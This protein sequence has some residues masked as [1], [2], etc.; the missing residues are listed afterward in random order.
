[1]ATDNTIARLRSL[2]IC[3]LSDALDALGLEPAVTGLVQASAGKPIAGRAVTVKLIAGN[4]PGGSKRHLC[5]QAVE[6]AGP[7]NIIVIEQRSGLDA[8]AWG[9]ILSRAAQVRGIAGTIVD[10]PARDIEESD[11]VGYSVY[12]RMLTCRTARGRIHES[13]SGKPIEF[14]DTIVNPGDYIAIDRSGCVVIPA[15]RIED[16]LSRAEQIRDK[17]DDMAAAVYRGLPVSKVMGGDYE[18]M[19]EE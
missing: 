17:S 13:E 12:A 9:G 1:M 18:K 7:D 5:T 16:V 4:A 10:G 8:A 6:E 2:D 11:R 14:G 3:D 19:L 15:T